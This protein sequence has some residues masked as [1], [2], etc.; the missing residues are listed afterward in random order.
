MYTLFAYAWFALPVPAQ[1]ANQY[2]MPP[3]RRVIF[4]FT[5]TFANLDSLKPQRWIWAPDSP[6]EH[7]QLIGESPYLPFLET[8]PYWGYRFGCWD[9]AS[10][11]APTANPELLRPRLCRQIEQRIIVARK[12]D[13]VMPVAI[14]HPLVWHLDP[15]CP[16]PRP[17][18]SEL[19]AVRVSSGGVEMALE[20]DYPRARRTWAD[21]FAEERMIEQA[22]TRMFRK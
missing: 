1:P 9:S 18:M 13:H 19:Y 2:E 21:Y 22:G 20:S 11:I 15:S 8:D 6:W 17:W 10:Y 12:R 5:P 3:V 14:I 7:H 16:L 4:S